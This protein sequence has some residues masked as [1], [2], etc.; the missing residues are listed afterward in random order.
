MET[1]DF[2]TLHEYRDHDTGGIL[3]DVEISSSAS[4]R[5]VAY[6]DSGAAHCIFDGQYAELIGLTL[7]NGEEK[8]FSTSDGGTIVGYGH[9]I[10]MTV[11]EPVINF[12]PLFSFV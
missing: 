9:E 7:N 11:L 2:E 10:S 6:V 12:I 8:R 5:L 1:L 3:L 4:T